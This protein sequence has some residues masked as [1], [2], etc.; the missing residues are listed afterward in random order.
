MKKKILRNDY[1]PLKSKFEKKMNKHFPGIIFGIIHTKFN[2]WMS[3]GVGVNE[4]VIK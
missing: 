4:W 2:F 1:L 3:K